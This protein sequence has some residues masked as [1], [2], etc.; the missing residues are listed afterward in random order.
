MTAF[1]TLICRKCGSAN[2]PVY[3][4]PV[5]VPGDLA[6]TCICFNCANARGWLDRDGNLKPGIKL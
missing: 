2:P 5:L 6:G 4:A 3:L 1:A